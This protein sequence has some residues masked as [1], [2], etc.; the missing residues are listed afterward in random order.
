TP[1][2]RL[3]IIGSPTQTSRTPQT[4]CGRLVA[5]A[6]RDRLELTS[7]MV[8]LRAKIL[9][10]RALIPAFLFF[11]LKL[12][13][14]S[15]IADPRRSTAGA[16]GGCILLRREALERIGGL[17]SICGE[18]IDDCALARAVKGS[19][20]RIGMGL[21]RASVSVRVYGN[22]GEI[23]DMIARTAFT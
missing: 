10:E 4:H 18:V 3:L 2:R 9:S 22:W 1:P 20:G 7:L 5:R 23:R 12:Y 17:A 14:P 6:E 11:F 19:G 8:L 21:T 13:P 15:W 16:A